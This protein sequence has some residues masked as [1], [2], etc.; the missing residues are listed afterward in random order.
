[1]E[2]LLSVVADKPEFGQN[3]HLLG[4]S[5]DS[6]T[7]SQ[8]ASKILANKPANID[9]KGIMVMDGV[10]GTIDRFSGCLTMAKK[11]V[12]KDTLKEMQ[13]FLPACDKEIKACQPSEPGGDPN[14]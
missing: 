10:T 5:F 1:Y 11:L 6:A 9:F 7:V 14:P 4:I 3:L 13:S 8:L 2:M 12:D